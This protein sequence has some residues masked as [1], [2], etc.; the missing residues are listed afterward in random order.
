MSLPEITSAVAELSTEEILALE[1]SLHQILR[2]RGAGLVYLDDYGTATD[3]Q[4]L[5][6]AD[7]AFAAYDA[8]EADAK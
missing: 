5:S 8:A 4:L 1:Q 6:E 3:A 2:Q 7:A